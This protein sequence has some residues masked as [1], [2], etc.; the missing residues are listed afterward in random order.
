MTLMNH[1]ILVFLS[2]GHC[3]DKVICLQGIY[4]TEVHD[5]SPAAK[6]GLRMHDKILQVRHCFVNPCIICAL[7][8][9]SLNNHT[10]ASC[11][12]CS[13][14]VTISQWWLIKRQWTTL[15][16]TL[17]WTYWLQGK[18]SHQRDGVLRGVVIA[19]YLLLCRC[20]SSVHN[21]SSLC[22]CEIH[23]SVSRGK[24]MARFVFAE[25]CVDGIQ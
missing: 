13:V 2:T 21:F 5:A 18:A 16:N 22:W 7:E 3:P 9:T 10:W 25:S 20:H 12:C 23:T 14:M 24:L 19:M 6:S 8:V 15:R 1:W 11:S 17:C 4:V